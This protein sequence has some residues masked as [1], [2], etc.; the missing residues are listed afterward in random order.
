MSVNKREQEVKLNSKPEDK[1]G[2]LTEGAILKVLMKLAFPIMVSAFL[3]TIYSITDM[4]WI[5]LLGSKAVAG[6]GVAGMYMWLSGGLATLAKTGGQVYVAQ[7]IGK[8]KRDEAVTYAKTAL[9][10]GIIFGIC[11][12]LVCVIFAEPMISFFHLDGKE[13]IRSA[14]IYLHISGGVV[15]FSYLGI[16]L[17]GIYTAQGNSKTPLKA[18]FCGL[19][20][21]MILDPVLILGIGPF[22]RLGVA[23]SAV[24]TVFAQMVV[25]IVLVAAIRGENETD[26][27]L[28]DVCLFGRAEGIS[29]E[30]M[31]VA[32]G[33]RICT[34]A[35]AA[36][37]S[38]PEKEYVISAL[39][40]GVPIAL[41]N[42]LYCM[43]SMVLSRLVSSFGDGAIAVQQVG[44]QIESISWNTADGFASAMNAF[45][46]QNYGAKKMERVKKGYRMSAAA[47]G[48]WGLLVAICFFLFSEQ[49]SGLFFH[50][51]E[52]IRLSVNYLVII[53]VGEAF[54]CVELM[55]V[56]ALS[57]MGKTTVCSV[58][59]IVLTGLRIPLAFVLS[60][61]AL[62][63]DGIWWA[64]TISSICKGVCLYA[65]FHW[66]MRKCM[67]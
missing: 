12:G 16:I 10:L 7:A 51:A 52:V 20:I 38:M 50:E 60:N 14:E 3:S 1:Q 30:E 21:N 24:A 35:S 40:I 33:E 63:L 42:T 2:N 22:P 9:Q 64:L 55:S 45:A 39:K 41:Q 34:A 54:M 6:V 62:G 17:T 29:K 5:G 13:A 18:N 25:V 15:I 57:G 61:T 37:V 44:G 56:G 67:V 27:V 19:V 48:A 66:V 31:P 59:S 47:V 65:A 49:I 23:G 28:K 32:A 46:A 26:H 43:I 11:F 8:G 4:A 58:I 36:L 53:G